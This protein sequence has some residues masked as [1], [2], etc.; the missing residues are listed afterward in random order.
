[1][2]LDLANAIDGALEGLVAPSFTTVGISARRRLFDWT[3][4]RSYDLSGRVVVVTGATSGLGRS[5]AETLAGIGATVVVLGRDA[6]RTAKAAEEIG[7]S[8]AAGSATAVVADM[9]DLGSVRRAAEEIL[10][11]H[12]R[13]D[14]VVHNAGALS[15]ERTESVDGTESTVASQVVGPFLLTTLLLDRLADGGPGRVITVSSGGMYTVGLTV[16]HLEMDEESYNGTRQYALAKRAQVTLNEMWAERHADAGVRFHAMHPGWAD[17]PGVETSLPTFHRV[18]GPLL[19]DPEAGADTMVW[20][21]AD[22]GEPLATNGLF[23][24]DR[25]PRSTHRLAST[26]R[27]DT[28]SRRRELWEWVTERAGLGP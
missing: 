23:W 22:D 15:A 27:T 3:D 18:V 8:G 10:A 12:D 4:L 16:N 17:T 2:A 11:H 1:M 9:S 24:H 28:P 5:A 25:R 20:L 7:A 6:E 19:R 13:L 26:R 14:A 21:V